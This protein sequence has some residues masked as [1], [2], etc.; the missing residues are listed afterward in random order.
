MP[1]EASEEPSALTSCDPASLPWL[2]EPLAWDSPPLPASPCSLDL[3]TY[4]PEIQ[5]ELAAL[6]VTVAYGLG[7]AV[8]AL[9]AIA[10]A[11][12]R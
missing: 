6:R 1:A 9:F 12:W 3:G 7:L 8:L 10:V 4:S 5:A 11:R 2:S